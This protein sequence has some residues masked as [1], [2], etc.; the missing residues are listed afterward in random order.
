MKRNTLFALA[1]GLMMVATAGVSAGTGKQEQN[2]RQAGKSTVYFYDLAASDTHGKGKLMID[3]EKH[4]FVFNGQGFEPLRHVSLRARAEGSSEFVVFSTAKATQSGNLHMAGTWEG[5]AA[6][7]EVGYSYYQKIF[8]MWL[9][10]DG[11]F[12][13]KVACYYS[14]DGGTTWTESDHSVGIVYGEEGI[15]PL[16]TINVPE[17]SLVRLHAVVV[18]GN[19][20]TG[21]EIFESASA[22]VYDS[23]DPKYAYYIISGTT[24]NDTLEYY[25]I[26]TWSD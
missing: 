11:L 10:N 12:V 3:V 21:S 19:D 26:L 13:T 4:T 18:A 25:G 1:L 17:Y 5:A 22:S 2:P 15:V 9:Y 20:K 23:S 16:W 8:G 14:T 24:L 7:A 6:P